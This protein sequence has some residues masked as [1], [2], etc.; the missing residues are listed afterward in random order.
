M[1]FIGID[2][3]KAKLDCCLLL[4]V[5]N[6]KRKSKS[7]ANSKFGFADMLAWCSKPLVA[8][9]DLHAIMESSG[10]YHE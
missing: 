10:A 7:V 5:A 6:G 4:D 1:F 3:S 9:A 8:P 2:V